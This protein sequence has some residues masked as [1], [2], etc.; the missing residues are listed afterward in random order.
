M[1]LFDPRWFWEPRLLLQVLFLVF[2]DDHWDQIKRLE[3][4]ALDRGHQ[5]ADLAIAWLLS[6]P[7]VNTVIAGVRK[8]EQVS[9]NVAA[10]SW[11]LTAEESKEVEDLCSGD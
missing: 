5:L 2:L 3:R 6:K 9:A 4:F 11:K 7:Y 10:A 8:K 1:Q